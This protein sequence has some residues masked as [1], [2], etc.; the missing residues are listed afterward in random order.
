MEAKNESGKW[1]FPGGSV[2]WEETLEQAINREI[3]EEYGF[4][5]EVVG[6]LTISDHDLVE[7]KKQFVIQ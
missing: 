6:L 3:N 7:Y 5:I 2:E 1:E 4:I